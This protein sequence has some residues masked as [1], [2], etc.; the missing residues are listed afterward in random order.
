MSGRGYFLGEEIVA[1][2]AIGVMPNV[3]MSVTSGAKVDGRFGKQDFVYIL[4]RDV[5]RCGGPARPPRISGEPSLFA[6]A[7]V[8][9][10]GSAS[11][12]WE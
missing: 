3:S 12:S 6:R 10:M 8:F 7:D 2:E 5:H 11:N 9:S 4:E 1:R